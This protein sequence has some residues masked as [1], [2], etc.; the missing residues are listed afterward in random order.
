MGNIMVIP[1]PNVNARLGARPHLPSG[2]RKCNKAVF[3]FG[4][5]S[6]IMRYCRLIVCVRT[7]RH[8]FWGDS[9]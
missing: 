6:K 8:R 7:I 5:Q 3:F 2:V 9:A 4:R 1:I